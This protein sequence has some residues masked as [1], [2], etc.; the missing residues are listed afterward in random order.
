MNKE[1]N[2]LE[3]VYVEDQIKLPVGS[4]SWIGKPKYTSVICITMTAGEKVWWEFAIGDRS[5]LDNIQDCIEEGKAVAVETFDNRKVLL[6]GRFI[7][8]A[9]PRLI[10]E[11]GLRNENKNCHIGDYTYRWLL[12]EGKHVTFV[13]EC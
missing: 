1:I 10:V 9:E 11:C 4:S 7:V 5:N 6:N 12:P 3:N 8:K 13:D 2:H